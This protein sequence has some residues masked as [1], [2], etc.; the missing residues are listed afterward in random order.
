MADAL[1]PLS[2]QPTQ[3]FCG[4]GATLVDALDSLCLMGFEDEC[5]QALNASLA[6]DFTTCLDDAEVNM[7]ES[8]IRIL[9]GLLAAYDLT[10]DVKLV[11]KLV[12]LGDVLHDAFRT[13]NG[14]PRTRYRLG[15]REV[16]PQAPS[17]APLAEVGTLSLE[18]ARLSQI[19]GDGKYMD[20]VDLLSQILAR[21]QQ[22]SGIPGLWPESI[23]PSS[24]GG[25]GSYFAKGGL[26]WSLGAGSDSAYE[27]LLKSHLLLGRQADLYRTMWKA[28]SERIKEHLLFRPAIPNT[29]GTD[30]LFSGT[31]VKVPN[32]EYLNLETKVQHLACFAGGMFA[33]ASRIFEE[34]QDLKLATQ[35]ANGCVWAYLNT[36]TGIMPE[37]FSVM[38]CPHEDPLNCE[39]AYRVLEGHGQPVCLNGACTDMLPP[40]FLEVSDPT[41][42][43]RPEAVESVFIMWRV[44]GNEHWREVGWTMFQSIIKH[45]RT[46]YG[47]A[48]LASTT[49]LVDRQAYE[50]EVWVSQRGPIQLDEMES[51]WFAETLKYF[52]LLFSEPD[53]IS[54][55]DYVLNTEAHPFRLTNGIRGFG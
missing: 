17:T 27:Y 39:D 8:T 7:F 18:F 31:A 4:W 45:T 48:S 38:R 44:T 26:R 30:V 54:L 36:P 16:R 14:M 25:Q 32:R 3:H 1:K 21:T 6:L 42:R 51:F 50:N 52:Y 24:V 9:G 23:H 43:L 33:L 22:D 19:T 46:P 20:A 40:G 5:Q 34:P 29:N 37:S 53:L 47:H 15:Q 41:Y 35:L 13:P 2:G 49:Q 28:A 55:D 11:S 10:N 12:E